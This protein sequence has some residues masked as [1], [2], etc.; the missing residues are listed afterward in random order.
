MPGRAKF[1][2]GSPV[3]DSYNRIPSLVASSIVIRHF[4]SSPDALRVLVPP[5]YDCSSDFI[6]VPVT[7]NRLYS[8]IS[9]QPTQQWTSSYKYPPD[10]DPALEAQVYCQ[11]LGRI[12]EIGR[13]GNEPESKIVQQC[14]H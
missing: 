5:I 8:G 7:K 14:M 9:R 10:V 11:Q 2:D 3:F 4:D 1:S 12:P 13:T 6:M